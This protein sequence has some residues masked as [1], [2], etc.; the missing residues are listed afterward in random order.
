LGMGAGPPS[1]GVT[2]PKI[3]LP[4]TIGTSSKILRN[5]FKY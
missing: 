1:I 5:D 2:G 3:L 4:I